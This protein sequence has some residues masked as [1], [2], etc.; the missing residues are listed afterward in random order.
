MTLTFQRLND[1][2]K[3]FEPLISDEVLKEKFYREATHKF[4]LCEKSPIGVIAYTLDIVGDKTM[5]RFIHV[6]FDNS[7]KGDKAE[8]LK[9]CEDALKLEGH[10]QTFA[11][12][13]LNKLYMQK[14]ALRHGFTEWH[15]DDESIYYY[16]NI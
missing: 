8:F 1:I 14:V 9:M 3:E 4:F 5:P 7:F 13:S 10:T 15:R 2:P 11:V 12:I 16:K 6:S